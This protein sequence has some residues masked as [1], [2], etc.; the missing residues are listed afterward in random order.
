[1]SDITFADVVH[2]SIA[3]SPQDKGEKLILDL[4]DTAWF[5]RLRDVSQTANTRLVYMFSEHSRFGHCVGVAYLA[6][7]VLEHLARKH[8]A[9]VEKHRTAILVAALLHDIG[10]L[11]PG[12]HTAFKTWFPGQ[13]DS[14]EA[15]AEIVITQDPEIVS[16]LNSYSPSLMKHV[17]DILDESDAIDPWAWQLIS[18]GGWNVDRGNWSTVDSVLAGVSY[19]KYNIPALADSIVITSNKQLALMENRLDAMMHFV[20]SRH[21]MYRQVYQHRVILAADMLNRAVVQRARDLG[22]GAVFADK[23]MATVLGCSDPETLNTET[24]FEMREF[25]WRYHL[26]RWREDK[27]KILSD[28]STRLLERRLLKTVRVP[29]DSDQTELFERAKVAVE[30]TGFDP[31]YYL[32]EISTMDVQAGDLEQSMSVLL[33]NGKT[34]RLTDADPLF[35]TLLRETKSGLKRWL[36][37]PKEAKELLG[38]S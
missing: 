4:L 37:M 26:M 6:K 7:L 36:A 14:H 35:N 38:I 25:W 18:G 15:L 34:L 13:P 9:D 17:L 21:A 5:Q 3:F 19:G 33:D 8:R 1:M 10:H 32:H 28:L 30:K 23:T 24:I 22:P 11:A 12:S 2:Q 27:D 16:L 31:R 20:V 29:M